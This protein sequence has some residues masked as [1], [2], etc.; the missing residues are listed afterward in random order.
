MLTHAFGVATFLIGSTALL[1]KAYSSHDFIGIA[2]AWIFSIS[3]ITL[4]TASTLYHYVTNT[5]LKRRFKLIDH[6]AIFILIAGTYSPILMVS[7]RNEIHFSFLLIMWIIA[8]VGIVYKVFFIK[9]YR[10][11]STFIYLAM[12][13]MAVFKIGTFYKYLPGEALAW[14][15]A[16]GL[17]YTVGTY[18]YSKGK[19]SYGHAIWHI[20]VLGGSICHFIAIYF[21]VY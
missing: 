1:V 5:V 7:L 8:L 14:I 13:W 11:F 21:Y 6:C 12:G 17:S 16:G 15:V 19:L 4:Y 18:F 9:K 20:F 10:L 3:L 2:G